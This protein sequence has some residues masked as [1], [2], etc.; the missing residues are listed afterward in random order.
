MTNTLTTNVKETIKQINDCAEE[1][2]E[3]LKF[4]SDEKVNKFFERNS[5]ESKFPLLQ[6]LFHYK[7]AIEAAKSGAKYLRINPGNIGKK[8][9]LNDNISS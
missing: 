6:I 8:K 4:V 1:G 2:A 3:L 7:R 9:K 5:K